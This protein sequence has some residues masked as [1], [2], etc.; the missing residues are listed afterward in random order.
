MN[1]LKRNT[2]SSKTYN[3]PL[4]AFVGIN[5]FTN[6]GDELY[7]IEIE[8]E[9]RDC[10][11]MASSLVGH[12][13]G[14]LDWT[15][16]D[17]GSLRG[18]AVE[19]I[20]RQP[21]SF[22]QVVRSLS[23]FGEVFGDFDQSQLSDRTSVHVHYNITNYTVL[24]LHKALTV[25][26]LLEALVT[27]RSA[28]AAREGNHFCLRSVD[29]QSS[30]DNIVEFLR[31]PNRNNNSFHDSGRYLNINLNSYSRF[32]TIEFRAHRG[33]TEVNELLRWILCI[34]E[35]MEAAK[36]FENPR[37]IMSYYSEYGLDEFMEEFFPMTYAY[38]D[39]NVNHPDHYE[40]F[41]VAQRVAYCVQEG[42]EGKEPMGKSP[43]PTVRARPLYRMRD[44]ELIDLL[45]EPEEL[46]DGF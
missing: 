18:E 9:G 23:S 5:N 3:R 44:E 15:Y 28:G 39:N 6:S 43:I 34:R 12:H 45:S 21:R 46:T 35:M 36:K 33:C 13:N 1:F 25:L 8:I 4:S 17:D 20:S 7:G 26:Y 31:D 37:Q 42:T 38:I 19:I 24:D 27:H 40:S 11:F 10:Q 14:V 16:T 30:V 2:I 29:A 22:D 41:K 32:G